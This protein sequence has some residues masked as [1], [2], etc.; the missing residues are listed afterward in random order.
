MQE[1]IAEVQ[2][3]G[4]LDPAARDELLENL[5]QADPAIWPLMVQQLRANLAWRRQARAR[6]AVEA[7]GSIGP[8]AG[9]P[10]PTPPPDQTARVPTNGQGNALQRPAESFPREGGL[11]GRGGELRPAGD[12]RLSLPEATRADSY[13]G[14]E[15]PPLSERVAQLPSSDQRAADES[16]ARVRAASYQLRSAHDWQA[17]M[18][19]AVGSL[20]SEVSGS[21]QSDDEF[22]QHARLRMLYLLGGQRDEALRPIPSMAPAMQEFWSEQLYGLATLLDPTLIAE[23]SH[24]KAEAK[25]HLEVAAVKLGESCPLVVRNLAFVTDIQSYG[26]YKPFD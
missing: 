9:P 22:A 19:Q 14:A 15:R 5:K 12:R 20:E 24:R 18:D 2:A 11:A 4:T 17:M 23:P 13:P 25:Q 21:P 16:A 1:V 26:T 3:L 8:D 6:E 10:R 7:R